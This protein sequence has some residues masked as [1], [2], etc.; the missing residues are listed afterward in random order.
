M[1]K[2]IFLGDSQ[3]ICCSDSIGNIFFFHD[4]A[5]KAKNKPL[6]EKKYKTTSL[7]SNKED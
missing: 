3:C 5:I 2:V 4:C 7:T 1:K 6:L